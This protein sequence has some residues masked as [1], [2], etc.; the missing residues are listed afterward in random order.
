MKKLLLATF[1]CAGML[2]KIFAQNGTVLVID[3]IAPKNA[4]FVGVVDASQT[5]VNTTLFSKNLSGADTDVQHALQTIDQLTASGGGGSAASVTS[6]FGSI[7]DSSTSLTQFGIGSTPTNLTTFNVSGST[8]QTTLTPLAGRIVIST[9]ANV[10]IWAVVNSTGSGV[11]DIRMWIGVNGTTQPITCGDTPSLRCAMSGELNLVSGST[12]SVMV[13]SSVANDTITVIDAQ[14]VI[15]TFGGAGS[16]GATGPQGP[17]GSGGSSVNVSPHSVL[18][19]TGGTTISGNT[20]L[21]YDDSVSSVTMNG[22]FGATTNSVNFRFEDYLGQGDPRIILDDEN[23]SPGFHFDFMSNG[24]VWG[25]IQ[26]QTTEF[27][28]EVTTCSGQSLNPAAR[29]DFPNNNQKIKFPNAATGLSAV[30]FD[31]L[32]SSTFSIPVVLSTLTINTQLIDSVGSSGSNTQVLTKTATG[33]KWQA[34]SGGGTSVSTNVVIVDIGCSANGG[35]VIISTGIRP[36]CSGMRF[37]YNFKISSWTITDFTTVGSS[38]TWDIYRTANGATNWSPTSGTSIVTGGTFPSLTNGFVNS[39]TP[40][41]WTSTAIN[42]GDS[43]D[44]VVTQSSATQSRFTVTI[45]KSQ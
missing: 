41:S 27:D 7:Y 8:S 17:A 42:A 6:V 43:L 31:P 18:F 3:K 21:Q 9:T 33:P 2:G 26:Q 15:G 20:G 13:N 24:V 35:G 19:S 16:T 23:G 4:A 36:D 11:R 40:A 1:L 34:S 38:I 30:E 25:N 14:L 45:I 5:V 28:I 39:S 12:V 44:F 22:P 10:G 29:I 37:D 32:S